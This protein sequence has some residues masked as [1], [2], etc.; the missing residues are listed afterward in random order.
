MKFSP[1]L[2]QFGPYG[3]LLVAGLAQAAANCERPTPELAQTS[4]VS[5]GRP[6][7]GDGMAL[8]DARKL[9]LAERALQSALFLGL[10]D[11][12]E[13]A[14]AH[15]YLAFIFCGNSEWL[16]C[17]TAFDAALEAQPAFILEAR[18][19]DG[20]PW[21]EVYLRSMAKSARRCGLP[22]SDAGLPSGST[23]G[24]PAPP[25]A[26]A[27]HSSVIVGV[28]PLPLAAAPRVASSGFS[29]LA[30]ESAPPRS[31]NNVRLRVSPWAYVQVDGKRLGVTPG[32][33]EFK[34]SP[35]A[36]TI[37]LRNPGFDLVRK[38]VRLPQDAPVL[39]SHDF[40]AR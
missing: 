20:T 8:F 6:S 29:A 12:Q 10:A 30:V 5:A 27:L 39:I 17:E 3:L 16:R 34:L 40:E 28:V 2:R 37:E 23:R 33:T 38:S 31:G 11:G 25:Q 24:T 22:A 9:K 15:K 7:L 35:G 18:E 36:H 14:T 13:R 26:F 32:L 1:L 21:R 4:G 19:L